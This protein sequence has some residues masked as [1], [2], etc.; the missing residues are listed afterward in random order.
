MKRGVMVTLL[1]LAGLGMM[2]GPALL[3]LTAVLFGAA[4]SASANPCVSP[5]GVVPAMGGPVRWP[6]VGQFQVT[7]EFGMRS[8]PGNL[9][10]GR[11]RLHAG[12]DLAE[13]PGPT[14]VVASMAGVVKATPTTAGGGNQI[15]IDHGLV[16]GR[17]E[18]AVLT[19]EA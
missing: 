16:P 5:I 19:V 15:L 4:A 17:I 14:T 1:L 3:G 13:R 7:S 2:I 11:Y 6:V 9:D 10:H 12:I 18:V 8:N